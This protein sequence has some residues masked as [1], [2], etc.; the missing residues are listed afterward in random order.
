MFGLT[1]NMQPRPP[2]PLQDPLAG[3]AR[4]WQDGS[5][6]VGY[7]NHLP[8]TDCGW[9]SGQFLSSPPL[10]GSLC[11]WVQGEATD[12]ILWHLIVA[13]LLTL[14]C[15]GVSQ[16]VASFG[17]TGFLSDFGCKLIFYFHRVGRHVS[18]WRICFQ[19]IF[20]AIKISSWNLRWVEL[21][22]K[23]PQ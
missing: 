4:N 17:V 3:T 11:H 20:Q 2:V 15:R 9:S 7:R 22:M 6:W 12:L 5:Q 14:L 16:T 18:I 23:S 19:S 21:K 13:N 8:V 10:P 1:G